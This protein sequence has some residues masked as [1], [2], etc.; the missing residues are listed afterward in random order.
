[1]T[2]TTMSSIDAKKSVIGR[3]FDILECFGDQ[4]EQTISTLCSQTGLPPA[5]VHRMLAALSE[6]GAVERCSRGNYR[7]GMRLWRLGW[8]VPEMRQLKDVARPVL[9]D[10]HRAT[11]E[12]VAVC[13]RVGYEIVVADVIAGQSA[14]P[15]DA[16]SRRVPLRGT[17]PG[18]VYLAF[19]DACGLDAQYTMDF[20]AR[21]RMHE[22]RRVGFAVGRSN[23]PK[24]TT[25]LAAPILDEIGQVRSSL[26]M[27]VPNERVNV[28]AMSGILVEASRRVSVNFLA[29]ITS[30]L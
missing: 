8:G 21:Q 28:T 12:M 26:A 23:S 19:G 4:P 16:D 30:V 25:W 9:V 27:I 29:P 7:L 2:V 6:W 5:T 18:D 15:L 1:V 22:I 14:A 11:G 20:A 10:L 3:V 24:G 13:S 17:A